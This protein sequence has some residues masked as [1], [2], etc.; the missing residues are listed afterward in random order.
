MECLVNVCRC[1]CHALLLHI[2]IHVYGMKLV[3]IPAMQLWDEVVEMKAAPV[4]CSVLQCVA[5]H[6]YMR[7]D[8][9]MYALSRLRHPY[10]CEL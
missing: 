8:T 4:W 3:E 9:P 6:L 2:H 10:V 1:M 5:T 7:C